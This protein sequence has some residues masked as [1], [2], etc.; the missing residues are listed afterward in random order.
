MSDAV[1]VPLA[2]ASAAVSTAEASSAAAASITTVTS[3]LATAE[4]LER[5]GFLL[6][7]IK[8]EFGILFEVEYFGWAGVLSRKVAVRA[9]NWAIRGLSGLE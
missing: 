3:E 5:V 9:P 6:W 8:P 4:R 1:A 2:L 7:S